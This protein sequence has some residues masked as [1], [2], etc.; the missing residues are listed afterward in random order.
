MTVAV[1]VRDAPAAEGPNRNDHTNR[2]P[3][4]AAVQRGVRARVR[5]VE[6]QVIEAE[7]TQLP[8]AG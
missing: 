2:R 5:R 4:V 6:I 7:S 1:A 3:I 8:E